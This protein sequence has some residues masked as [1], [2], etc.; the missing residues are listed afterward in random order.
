ML[1]GVARYVVI[2]THVSDLQSIPSEPAHPSDA[3]D[4]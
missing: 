1:F 2:A 4:S 3:T